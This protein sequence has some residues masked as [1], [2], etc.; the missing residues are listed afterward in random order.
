VY[1]DTGRH[2]G[3]IEE[4]GLDEGQLDTPT[5]L[6]WSGPGQLLVWDP[7][8]SWVSRFAVSGSGVRFQDRFLAFAFGETGFCASRDRTYL[9]YFQGGQV[10]HEIGPQGLLRSFGP[11]P[12][13]VGMETLGPELQEIATEELTP[14]ALL[15]TGHGLLETSLMQSQVRMYD[16]DGALLWGRELE[17][18]RPIYV[19]TPDG[20]GLG[21]GFD[22][23]QGSHLLRSAVPWG[24]DMALLQYELRTQEIPEEGEVEVIESRLVRLEDGEEVART[25]ALPVVLSAQGS[26]LYLIQTDPFPTVIVAE[27]S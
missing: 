10:V 11:V 3:S 21:R 16:W 5:G 15:C 7:G 9:S 24:D 6:A 23:A 12:A 13:V 19:Y 2:V 22:A 17:G 20:M 18:F 1:D 4:T 26:R 14:S 8:S 25:R 27:A